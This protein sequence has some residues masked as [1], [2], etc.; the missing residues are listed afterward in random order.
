MHNMKQNISFLMAIPGAKCLCPSYELKIL[1]KPKFPQVWT[2][3]DL[4]WIASAQK[5]LIRIY[6]FIYR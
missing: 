6:L 1:F 5:K 2:P 4:T 3:I